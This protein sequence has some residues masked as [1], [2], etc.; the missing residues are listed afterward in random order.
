MWDTG[1]FAH[2]A[3]SGL[4]NPPVIGGSFLSDQSDGG[5]LA[6]NFLSRLWVRPLLQLYGCSRWTNWHGPILRLMPEA[7]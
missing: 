1:W 5:N 2:L 3:V 7:V 4:R 6:M